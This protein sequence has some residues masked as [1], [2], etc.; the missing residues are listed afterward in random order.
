MQ[1]TVVLL[2]DGLGERWS[3]APFAELH[4]PLARSLLHD[5]L[6]M[7]GGLRDIRLIL[8]Y[9]PGLPREALAHLPRDLA[10]APLREHGA[11]AVAEAFFDVLAEP[12][13]A[14]LLSGTAPHLPLWRVRD[15]FTHLAQGAGLVLGPGSHDDWYLLGLRQP[16]GDLVQTLPARHASPARLLSRARALRQRVVCL[17]PWFE[18][19]GPDDLVGLNEVLQPMPPECAPQTRELLARSLGR[20]RAVGG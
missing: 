7:L 15:A 17:P 6:A 20:A 9:G 13:P 5:M 10:I 4:E 14:V 18:L 12:G 3:Q 19:H 16:I 2:A 1:P 11:A 8:R